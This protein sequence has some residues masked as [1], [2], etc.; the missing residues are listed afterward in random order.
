MSAMW[1][2]RTDGCSER[3]AFCQNAVLSMAN[4]PSAEHCGDARDAR[5]QCVRTSAEQARHRF[6]ART[7]RCTLECVQ[8]VRGRIAQFRH[9][10]FPFLFLRHATWGFLTATTNDEFLRLA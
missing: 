8:F 7:P 3:A 1:R 6:I 4:L 9:G 10:G 2:R 5:T